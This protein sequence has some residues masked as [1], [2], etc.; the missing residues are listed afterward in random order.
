MRVFG[1]D[2]CRSGWIAVWI[3]E[4]DARGFELLSHISALLNHK[5]KLV[6][7]DIPIGLHNAYRACDLAARE[8]L[9][10]S[11]SRV[12]LGAR[13]F[14][15]R[16]RLIQSYSK[17]NQEA[18]ALYGKGISRQLF[19]LLPK[20]KEVDDFMTST[21]ARLVRETHPE[22][23]FFRLNRYKNL[24]SKKTIRGKQQRREILIREGFP[25]IDSWCRLLKGSGAK[26]DDLFDASA[27]ALAALSPTRL[28]CVRETD[29]NGLSIEMW[30]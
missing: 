18:K 30:Y 21:R 13:R 3:D 20:I 17:A 24:D 8:M 23:I 10:A 25:E 1:L 16:P 29:P 19:C 6:L 14:L 12:F 5:P 22:L 27:A 11:R 9:G 15:L 28:A 4:T 26:V 2:G 7:I